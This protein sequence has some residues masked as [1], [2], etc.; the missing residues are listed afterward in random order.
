LL[1]KVTFEIKSGSRVELLQMEAVAEAWTRLGDDDWADGAVLGA[2]ATAVEAVKEAVAWFPGAAVKA[3]RTARFPDAA[4][5]WRRSGWWQCRRGRDKFWK[6]GGF[7][8]KILRL[9]FKYRA[10]G[11]FIGG[12]Q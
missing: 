11:G 9:W 12:P 1:L 3:R 6:P 10:A 5:V 4:M 7:P 8:V 2:V